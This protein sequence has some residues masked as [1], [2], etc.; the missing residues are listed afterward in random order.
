MDEREREEST[1]GEAGDGVDLESV[2]EALDRGEI[3]VAEARERLAGVRRIGEGGTEFARVDARQGERTGIPEVVEAERKT[4]GEL[5]GIARELLAST[6]RAILTGVPESARDDLEAAAADSEVY[7]HS[8][9]LVL[10]AEDYEPPE[11]CGRVGVV[12]AGTSDI[13]VAEQAAA[14]ADEM[15]CRV[16]T[17]YDVGVSAIHRLFAERETLE[18][19]D[20]VVV[21]AGREG[22]LAT[23][24]AGLVSAPVIG[25]P[26]GTGTGYGGNGEAALLG[27]LQSCTYLTV[28]NVDAGFV[29]GGQAALVA[30]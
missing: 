19:C 25:L 3:A 9:T 15:G 23:V 4:D 10:H 7:E 12:T 11:R 21:A 27:M 5:L 26:V 24:V 29:A 1:A 17:I 14:L 28:V 22:A 8:G 6:G 2:L 16:E 13:A 20:C 18:T 30:R